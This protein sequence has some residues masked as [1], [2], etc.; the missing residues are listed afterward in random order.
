MSYLEK[1]KREHLTSIDL[2]KLLSHL[3]QEYEIIIK[4]H[5]NE[6][7][8]RSKYN[9]LD[10][11]IHCFYNEFVDIQELYILCESMITD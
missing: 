4:L 6:G 2:K 5:P 7:M 11:R 10:A 3:P 1:D 9:N 8:L